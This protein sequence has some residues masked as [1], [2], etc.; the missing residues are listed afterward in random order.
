M[1]RK[2]TCSDST[3]VAGIHYDTLAGDFLPSLGRAFLTSLYECMLN[4]NTGFG[5]VYEEDQRVIGAV[6]AVEDMN[7]FYK[8]M[9][10]KSFRILTPKVIPPLFKKPLL[11]KQIFET[12]LFSYKMDEGRDVK[13]ELLFL[14]V[15]EGYQRRGIGT[16]LVDALNR[17]FRTRAIKRYVVR[18][19]A[20]NK[21][22]NNFYQRFG[23]RLQNSYIMYGRRWN[24]Y[25]Y[26]LNT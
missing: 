18:V 26:H 3:H 12:L 6:V 11:I 4:L 2:M 19:Y 1:I 22:A 17:E 21:R 23:F 20:D 8:D 7:H 13:A 15:S 14:G 9:F 16:D 25:L 10:L 24:L 5:F